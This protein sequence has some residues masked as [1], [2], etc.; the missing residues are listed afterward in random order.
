M[1]ETGDGRPFFGRTLATAA[2]VFSLAST[3]VAGISA[4][5]A[6]KAKSQS[7]KT[8]AELSA[9]KLT[10]DYQIQ[11]FQM[12][13]KSLAGDGGLV[14]ASAYVSSLDNKE[15]KGS[16]GQALRTVGQVRQHAGKL[17]PE[18]VTALAL[19]TDAVRSTD[20]APEAAPA[21]GGGTT[22]PPPTATA[23]ASP[24][25]N[26]GPAA[27]VVQSTVNAAGWDVDVFWCEG[28]GAPSQQLATRIG[29]ALG[30][31]ANTGAT[32]GGQALGRIRVRM[33]SNASASRGGYPVASNEVRADP[34]EESFA[35][36]LGGLANGLPGVAGFRT[37]PSTSSTRWY[38]SLFACGV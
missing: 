34:G 2:A 27:K 7:E 15:L 18:E 37:T 32:L 21:G 8:Q 35:N 26:A 12:V 6:E 29:Q 5:Y 30:A 24:L 16:L 22:A 3:V 20:V 9:T 10:K 33:L 25:S 31:Q 36:A 28:K 38:V 19:M 1:A 11:V 23:V 17:T 14:L 4:Y 13:D